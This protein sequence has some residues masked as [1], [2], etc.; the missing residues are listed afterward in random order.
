MQKNSQFTLFTQRRFAPFFWTQFLGALNDNVFKTALLT[1]LTYDALSWTDLDPGLLNNLIPGLFILPFFL[2]SATSGQLADKL[3]KGRVARFVKLLEIAIMGIAAYGWMTHHLW[4]LVAAV[5]GMGVHS[6]LFGPVKYAYLPQQLRREELIGGN[7]LIE[8]GTFVGI[9]LGEILGAVLVVHKPWGLHLVAGMTIGIAVLGWLASL[10]IPLSP[11]PVPELKVNWNP[12]TETVR[13]LAYSRRNRPVFLSLLG[14]SWFWFYGAIMLAQFP[15]YAKNYLHGDH[16]VF[17]LLLAVFSVGIGAGSLLCERLSGHKVEIGLVPF[18]SIGL[19]VF[20]LE[21]YFASQAYVTPTAMLDLGGFLAQGGS[22]RILIDCL[23][24]GVFGGLYIVP[25]FALIQTRCDPAHVSRTIAGMNIMNAL[26]MVV[27]ALVA[28]VLL[29]AGLSIPQ[30]FLAT[31]I[32]NGVVAAYIFSLVPEFLIRFLAWI[33]IHTFYRVRIINGQAIPEQGPAV[34]VCNHVSY[35]DAIAIM[36]ASP[37][38]VRFV[39]DHQIFR[40]P[41]MSWLFRNVRAIPIAPVKEDPWLT[42][43]AFVDIAQALHEGELVCIFPEGK[44]TRDGELNPFKGGVQKIIARSPVPVLPMALRG[45]WGSLFSRDPS[46]PV[47]RTFKR[48]LFSRLELAV[49]EAIPP[50]QVSPELLQ[51]KVRELRGQWK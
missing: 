51:E 27:S 49:G 40:I 38:P 22:W 10:R 33:L 29:K 2:F 21:L 6:T 35:V 32:M 1:I 39:M 19:S 48:G 42:E 7:G 16:S 36:A 31:A 15:V 11:A 14:N 18:G 13:N 23:G 26:F 12:F 25:L 45:L 28:M 34:L 9:L 30:I 17:V 3:E 4:L 20:G 41:V 46:N 50:E 37:R 44:L 47:A 5:I 24:I 8:M 43:K